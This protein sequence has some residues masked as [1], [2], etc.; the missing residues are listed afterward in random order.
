MWNPNVAVS[1]FIATK[2]IYP[3]RI[4]YRFV[5][6]GSFHL[7][8]LASEIAL[9]L[10]YHSTRFY[11]VRPRLKVGRF[12]QWYTVKDLRVWENNKTRRGIF[13]SR[14]KSLRTMISISGKTAWTSCYNG[15]FN[16][17]KKLVPNERSRNGNKMC[18][19][20]I[21]GISWMR[22][23]FLDGWVSNFESLDISL[24]TGFWKFFFWLW[25]AQD[26]CGLEN[27]ILDTTMHNQKSHWAISGDEGMPRIKNTDFEKSVQ[28][29]KC[30]RKLYRGRRISGVS[31][32]FWIRYTITQTFC[33]ILTSKCF[34]VFCDF[35]RLQL[36]SQFTLA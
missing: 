16:M 7:T 5:A 10:W 21:F 2:W 34:F 31:R 12:S 22:S 26:R 30:R 20:S 35:L 4:R 18:D 15:K 36:N 28:E 1:L 14:C 9:V 25:D 11:P 32:R 17:A 13:E 24:G 19:I 3:K 33:C 27:I 23:L 6:D 29:V 8:G